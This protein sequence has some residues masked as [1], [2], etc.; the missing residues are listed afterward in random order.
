MLFGEQ[1][2]NMYK[3]ASIM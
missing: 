1:T 2:Y 3:V